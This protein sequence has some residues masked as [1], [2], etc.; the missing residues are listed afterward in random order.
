MSGEAEMGYV[1]TSV[2]PG[3]KCEAVSEAAA[4][5]HPDHFYTPR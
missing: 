4:A 1:V 5:V 2:S 3:E